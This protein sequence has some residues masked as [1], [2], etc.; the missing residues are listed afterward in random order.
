MRIAQT[1]FVGTK[2]PTSDGDKAKWLFYKKNLESYLA[3]SRLSELFKDTIG[4]NA[5][6]DCCIPL[7]SATDE[8]TVELKHIQRM[9][10]KAAGMMLLNSILN[11]T[12]KGQSVFYLVEKFHNAQAGFAG[13]QFYEDWMAL[14]K[15]HEEVEAK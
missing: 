4:K 6:K 3:R 8:E 12:E 10:Q 7:S 1:G 15:R 5:E 9:N 11:E 2:V 14:T 13:G